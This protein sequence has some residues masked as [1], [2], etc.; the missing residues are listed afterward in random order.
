[1]SQN[2]S[3]QPTIRPT[4]IRPS[5]I[6]PTYTQ[7][8]TKN[9]ITTVPDHIIP[10]ISGPNKPP[11][12]TIKNILEPMKTKPEP[13]RCY[14]CNGM[15]IIRFKKLVTCSG[16]AGTGRNMRIRAY[17]G[18]CRTCNGT[19]V[20]ETEFNGTCSICNGSGITY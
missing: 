15:G 1:M 13:I 5:Y 11:T 4:I 9:R 19:Q 20:M 3:I 18:Y 7:S 6:Q 10:F 2:R 14:T 17:M 8:I 16:C 12:S